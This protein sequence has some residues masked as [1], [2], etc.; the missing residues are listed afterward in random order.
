MKLTP[1]SWAA[2]ALTSAE[3]NTKPMT[4]P[5]AVPCRAKI[6]DSHITM[7]RVWPRFMPTARSRPSSRVRS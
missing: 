4:T 6:T 3:P 1:S 2:M 5:M 7:A